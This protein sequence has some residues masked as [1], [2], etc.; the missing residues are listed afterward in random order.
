[1]D[2]AIELLKS[3]GGYVWISPDGEELVL[4]LYLYT[5]EQKQ[6]LLSILVDFTPGEED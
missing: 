4:D 1:M 3:A 6:A 5:E 2:E